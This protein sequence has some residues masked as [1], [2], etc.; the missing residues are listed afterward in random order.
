MR[1]EQI[2][3]KG[4]RLMT[5]GSSVRAVIEGL[6]TQTVMVCCAN[7]AEERTIRAMGMKRLII[8]LVLVAYK[9]NQKR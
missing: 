7:A 3:P 9:S 4:A 6:L 5:T 2:S 1:A 8:Q